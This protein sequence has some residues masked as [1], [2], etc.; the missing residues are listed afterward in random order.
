MH[1]ERQQSI[2]ILRMEHGK[3]NAMDI[4][5]FVDMKR[6]LDE[7]ERSEARGVVL[8]GMGKIFSAGVDLFRIL[9][10][11]PKYVHAFL[12]ALQSGL[13]RVFTFKKPLIAAVNGH[14]IAGGCIL[15]CAS[16]FKVMAEGSG[17]IGVPERV[18]GVPFP[19]LALEIVRFSVANEIMQ[20]L[21]YRG[22]TYGTA[23]ALQKGL[24]DEAVSPEKLLSRAVE[25]AEQF[26]A[27]PETF[28]IM[29]EQ[30]RR[31]ALERFER[32]HRAHDAKAAQVWASAEA[33]QAIRAYLDRVIGKKSS[34]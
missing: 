4:E 9:E 13:M 20:E 34:G 27:A 5:F 14:A 3:A 19:T 32:D 25:L 26:G 17:T 16:D 7:L 8:T 11:G 29:K 22:K 31:P 2:A 18:V 1:I 30:L 10:E 28:S 24:I 33:H 23:E 6:C 21:V 15:V 12:E